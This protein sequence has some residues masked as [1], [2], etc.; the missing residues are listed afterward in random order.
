MTATDRKLDELVKR[1]KEAAGDNLESVILYG[2]AGRGEVRGKHD[3]LNVL[4]T[5]RSTAVADLASLAPTVKWWCN[6]QEERAPVFFTLEELCQSA[7]VFAIELLDMQKGHRVVYGSDPVAAIPV[8][9]NL[10][11]VQVE[12]DLRTLVLKLRHHFLH[13]C[14]EDRELRGVIAKSFSSVL[15]LLRHLL[16]AFGEEPPAAPLDI[17]ARIAAR[18]GA[19]AGAFAAALEIRDNGEHREELSRIYG[20]Y[21][22]ALEK[23]T[24][25][26]DRILPKREWRRHPDNSST[27][28]HN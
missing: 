26:L 21:L 10:H 14:G 15:T 8:P 2:S 25:A 18:T 28:S 1:L 23:A 12:H 27:H 11:R 6:R 7:D 22:E 5:L 13:A 3:D 17:F 20:R 4:C 24:A 16:I 9:M 19:D